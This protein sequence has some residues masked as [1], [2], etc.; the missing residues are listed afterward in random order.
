M[1]PFFVDCTA[2]YARSRGPYSNTHS[3][4]TTPQPHSGLLEIDYGSDENAIP[5]DEVEPVENIVKR[6]CT[7]AMSYGSISLEAHTTLA[8]AMNRYVRSSFTLGSCALS[9]FPI[10]N[11]SCRPAVG[12][13]R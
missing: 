4:L 11:A 3:L 9:F 12:V 1:E 13:P 2:T 10:R 7:G 5:L 8:I 6:F